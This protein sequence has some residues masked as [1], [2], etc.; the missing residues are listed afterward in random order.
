[1][2]EAAGTKLVGVMYATLRG[3]GLEG[4]AA[5]HATRRLRVLVHGFAS[6][7]SAGGFGLPEELD[8]TYDQIVRMYLASLRNES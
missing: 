2:Q 7:E 8:E 3:Y 1:V 6:V 5:V 4:P